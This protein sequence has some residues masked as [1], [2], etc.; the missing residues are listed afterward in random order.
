MACRRGGVD[1]SGS[2]DYPDRLLA[3]AKCMAILL[4]TLR[5]SALAKNIQRTGAERPTCTQNAGTTDQ[6]RADHW[7]KQEPGMRLPAQFKNEMVKQRADQFAPQRGKQTAGCA[8]HAEL[9][10]SR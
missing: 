5:R 9:Q 8:K 3:V 6:Q 1:D 2:S 4:L 7:Q 10:A